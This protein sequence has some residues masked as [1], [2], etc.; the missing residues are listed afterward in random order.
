MVEPKIEEFL[1]VWQRIAAEAPVHDWE[2]TQPVTRW[3]AEFGKRVT[4]EETL[5]L[6]KAMHAEM[7]A[8]F[9]DADAWV[10]PTVAVAPPRIGAWKGLAPPEAFAHAATLG[11]FTAGFNVSGQP[12]VSIP[13]GHTSHGHPIGVQIAG[14]PHADATVLALAR[15]LELARPWADAWP[16]LAAFR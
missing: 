5:R 4:P 12:A 3:L 15:Q 14:R 9:G 6:I 10:T 16:R 1:P 11:V 2:L 8:W 7:I 13:A